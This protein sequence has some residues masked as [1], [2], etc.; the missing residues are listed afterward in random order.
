MKSRGDRGGTRS[1]SRVAC[2]ARHA[3]RRRPAR[4]RCPP[5]FRAAARSSP[6]RSICRAGTDRSR[7]SCSGTDPAR[8]PAINSDGCRRG[9]RSSD[10]R[11]CASTSAASA[12]RPAPTSFVGVNDS[13]TGLPGPGR[14]RGRGC[15][16]PA[17]AAGNRS[18]Q[19][20]AR[21]QQPGGLDPAPRGA[22]ARRRR[23]H[24]PPRRSGV[25]R[26]TGDLLQRSRRVQHIASLDEVNALLPKFAGAPGF[27]P[28]PVLARREH[29]HALAA[30]R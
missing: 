25:Q 11:C 17:H 12:N 24:G 19:D 9:S 15:P 8:S 21:R 10:S 1:D 4:R 23:V 30:R 27:D 6:S 28:V 18:A 26:R 2:G 22:R 5:R 13:V 29:A 16:L 3:R 7:P 14:R 20:R